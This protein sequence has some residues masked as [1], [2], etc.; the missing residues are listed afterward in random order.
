MKRGLFSGIVTRLRLLLLVGGLVTVAACLAGFVQLREI[1]SAHRALTQ[2]ALPVL[3][4]TQAVERELSN[5]FMS[6]ERATLAENASQLS[7]AQDELLLK[8]QS[9]R[10]QVLNVAEAREHSD[11]TDRL[12]ARLDRLERSTEELFEQKKTLF[13]TEAQLEA[14]KR[15]LTGVRTDAR[16]ALENLNYQITVEIEALLSQAR[17]G[18][19]R[20]VDII[21]QLFSDLFLASLN[22]NSLSMDIETVIDLARFDQGNET[23]KTFFQ[24]RTT[25][26]RKL[27]RIA[28]ILAQ[29]NPSAQRTELAGLT[30]RLNSG[31]L[32]DAGL[33]AIGE[34]RFAH[35]EKLIALRQARVALASEISQFVEV[36]TEQS[37]ASVA[38]KS[39]LLNT[40]TQL[41]S[42]VLAVSL[43]LAAMTTLVGNS[44]IIEKQINSRMGR[45]HHAVREIAEGNLDHKIDVGGQDELGDLARALSIFKQNAEELKRSN[46][47]LERFAYV[48]AHDLRSPLRAVYDLAEWTL[49]DEENAL[50]TDSRS[51]LEMM[52]SRAK[53][54][55][56]LLTDLLDYARAGQ[57]NDGLADLDMARQ[58]DQISTMLNPKDGFTIKYTGA[59]GEIRTH[60]TPLTQI[61]INL[62]SNAIKHHDCTTG[63]ITVSARFEG[64]QFFVEVADDGPG[65]PQE[66]QERIYQLF[67]TLRPRDEVEGSGLGLAIIR[68]LL[69]RYKADIVL[70]SNPEKERGARFRFS[71][72]AEE[73]AEISQATQADA[74]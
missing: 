58:I 51:Y 12:I 30:I 10:D 66:Y 52:Q 34:A 73:C 65:I 44:I 47:D 71:F 3:I 69:D 9:F 13:R 17:E 22:L 56:R 27:R 50:S 49:E 11:L 14:L 25:L 57:E 4:Q 35:K 40:A 18:S 7:K 63:N 8:I 64:E 74:A 59:V 36:L 42:L 45:L 28:S 72:P 23:A 1:S 24:L 61:L 54:L 68:K 38:E 5:M 33:I 43:L 37:V 48:A 41:L 32:G 60:T 55:D 21:D 2:G 26:E 31:L 15:E 29:I 20:S 46:V 70:D 39:Q 16:E 67:Q 6:L 62:I 53:R 19:I